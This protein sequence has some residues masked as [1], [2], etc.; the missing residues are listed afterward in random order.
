M[1][2][3]ESSPKPQIKSV[4]SLAL[5]FF[6]VLLSHPYMT[7]RKTVALTRRSFVG[8]VMP[9][10]FN[11]LLRFVIAFRPRSKH[12]FNFMA[13]VTIYCDFGAKVNKV[14]PCFH[15]FSIYLHW[16]DGIWCHGLHFLNAELVI[17]QDF[18]FLLSLWSKDSLVPLHFLP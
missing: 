14:S 11:M 9:L 15:C 7:N 1:N 13:A 3:Q 12:L 17:S 4:N 6:M 8:K 10:L 2:S 5:S 16:G 18:H